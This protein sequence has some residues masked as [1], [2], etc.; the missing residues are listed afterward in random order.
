MERSVSILRAAVVG[1]NVVVYLLFM[2][3]NTPRPALAWTII[4]IAVPYAIWSLVFRPYER[5]PLLRFGA[6][7]IV[8]DSILIALWILGT[9]GA[10]SDFWVVYVV[11]AVSVGMRYDLATSLLVGA[12]ESA[13][14]LA[15]MTMDGGLPGAAAILRPGYIV[16][17]AGAAGLV[18]RQERTTREER[19]LFERLASEH[20]EML[21][22][23]RQT[24][25]AL[26]EVDQMKT[27]F[28]SA[29]SHEVRTPL[30]AVLGFAKT[31]M[32]RDH[33]LT[34]E[35]KAEI[36]HR[37][38]ASGERLERILMDLLDLNAY[39]NGVAQLHRG[40]T[41]V[42]DVV[43]R[44]LDEVAVG[45]HPIE[46]D[47]PGGLTAAVDAPKVERIVSNLVRNAVKYTPS[48]LPITVRACRMNGGTLIIVDDR[49]EGIPDD[50][51]AAIFQVFRQ[52]PQ[53]VEHAPGTGIGLALVARL[54]EL[55]GGRAW[56]EDRADGGASFRVML[57]DGAPGARTGPGM[58][59][60]ALSD[61]ASL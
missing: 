57:P 9:G 53:R 34:V 32:S 15:M 4:A 6:A 33:V 23:E 54:S 44:V 29:I 38:V 19:V 16:I 50:H 51:K 1:V 5:Y 31:L 8:S 12:A 7:T 43:Q 40:P 55:H 10:A 35:E 59:G 13:L 36:L 14:Y 18:A 27:T 26:R 24:V 2:Q 47:V 48:G 61:A 41:R 45:D 56:V 52:G 42:A 25:E 58:S 39:T 30:T 11:S 17:A 20:A 28:I 60:A 49:G 22:R 37:I 21:S 46:V 3:G